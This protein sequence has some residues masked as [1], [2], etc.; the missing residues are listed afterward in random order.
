MTDSGSAITE[1][2]FDL[3]SLREPIKVLSLLGD[4]LK[5]YTLKFLTA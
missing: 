3:F 1:F 5:G 4:I 2:A